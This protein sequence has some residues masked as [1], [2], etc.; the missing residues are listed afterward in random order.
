MKVS[1][2]LATYNGDR[3]LEA[4]L[5]SFA[6]Q[7]RLPDEMVV[8]DDK[9]TDGTVRLLEAFKLRAPFEV[10][11]HI[12]ANN[13][14]LTKNFEKALSLCRGDVIFLSDQDD[15]WFDIKIATVLGALEQNAWAQVV[16][17]DQVITDANLRPTQFTKMGHLRSVGQRVE[18]LITGCCTAL[19]SE[20]RDFCVP[21]PLSVTAHDKWIGDS[22][23]ALGIRFTL[24]EPLQFYRRHG[25]NASNWIMSSQ[26]RVTKFGLIRA[27]GQPPATLGWRKRINT[28]RQTAARI[29]AIKFAIPAGVQAQHAIISER[30]KALELRIN[31]VSLPHL[32]RPIYIWKLLRAGGYNG[33]G[34]AVLDLFRKK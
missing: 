19:R 16:V 20:F 32:K 1:I 30:I 17:N 21:F 5:D 25:R 14:G 9:S 34:G 4:Q 13:L 10:R 22:A 12:N 2:A 28:L 6:R 33:V 15:V 27:G 31:I 23:I 8:C 29:D 7:T 11:V 24:A 3:Y 18:G 26:T